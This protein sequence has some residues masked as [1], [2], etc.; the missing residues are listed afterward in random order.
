MI[1][2]ALIGPDG[3]GK[4]TITE[5]LEREPLPAP[6]TR[7]YMGV[8]LEA[9]GLMLPTTRLAMAI[10]A[11]RGRRPDMTGPGVPRPPITGGPA[12]RAVKAGARGVRLVLWLAEEW[13][14][15]IVAEY[16]RRRGRIVLFDR[17]FYADYYHFDVATEDRR[18]V[19]SR[20][21]GWL[22][23]NVYPKPD[24]VICLDAPGQVLFDRKGE[25]SPEWLEGRRRQYL[26]L[27]AVIPDFVVVDVNRPLD[28][29]TR[30]V[31]TVVS[32]FYLKR[33]KRP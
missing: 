29:V 3:A 11:R 32:E 13:F 15:Q 19:S 23:K 16:H 2:V 7:I 14:R 33:K 26:Q 20:L 27:S 10:K 9:S 18:P 24:L 5:L 31:A 1:S 12:K 6:V 22:L 4:S 28:V 25:A 21:H 30:E 17:H 8:N